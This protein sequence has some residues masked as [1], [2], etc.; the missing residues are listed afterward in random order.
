MD[1]LLP[2]TVSSSTASTVLDARWWSS[3]ARRCS[4]VLRGCVRAPMAM[5]FAF[6]FFDLGIW[7]EQRTSRRRRDRAPLREREV[8]TEVVLETSSSIRQHDAGDV[9]R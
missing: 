6:G 2:E 5:V 3:T 9:D 7:K 1:M 4:T 8:D